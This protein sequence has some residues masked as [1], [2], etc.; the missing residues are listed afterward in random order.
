MFY[1]TAEEYDKVIA[2]AE[3]IHKKPILEITYGTM[4]YSEES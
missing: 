1:Y 4:D 2:I 3:N